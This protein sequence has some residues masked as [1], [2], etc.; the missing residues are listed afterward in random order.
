MRD[1][2]SDERTIDNVVYGGVQ[3]GA[4]NEDTACFLD[5]QPSVGLAIYQQPG[6]NAL[7]TA[8]N[9]APTDAG[10]EPNVPARS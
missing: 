7:T 10:T 1:V 3:L 6:S 2:I 9:V 4:K 5:G 8:E